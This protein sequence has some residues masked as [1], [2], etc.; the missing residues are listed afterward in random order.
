MNLFRLATRE[1]RSNPGASMLAVLL[2]GLGI[3]MLIAV[4]LFVRQVEERLV[5][6]ARGIDLVVGAKGSPLQLV[7][8]GVYHLDAPTGNIPQDEA[9][10]IA[11]L[12]GVSAA[13]SLALGD[14]FRGF[15]IVGAPLDYIAHFGGRLNEG[16]EYGKPMEAV[17]GSDVARVT[18]LISG[19]EFVGSHGLVEGGAEHAGHPYRVV[20]V[21][22]PTGGPLDRL[23]LTPIESIWATHGGHDADTHHEEAGAQH[24]EEQNAAGT[25]NRE[26]TVVLVSFAS[27]LGAVT[28]PRL[29]N[30][31]GTLQSASPAFE[32]ARLMR[33]AGIGRDALIGF[34]GL[35]VGAAALALLVALLTALRGRRYDI[36]VMRLLGASRMDIFGGV[37]IEGFLL[38][39]L[40]AF[41]GQAIGYALIAGLSAWVS[42]SGQADLLGTVGI[43]DVVWVFPLAWIV[44]LLASS[45][46]ALR[47]SRTDVSAMLARG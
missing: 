21:L 2:L 42:A 45:I 10:K 39:T 28:L 8:S 7:L 44:G 15:R 22:A 1:M 35:L 13:I 18:G 47:A 11:R 26:V 4:L 43:A 37:L 5:R 3:A 41:A 14:S 34:A 27:P 46:P 29:I 31:V 19:R 36:A 12:P 20:G 25:A 38:S 40:G 17:L 23:V 30:Q 32:I 16:R 6:D 9:Q 24:H 33:L